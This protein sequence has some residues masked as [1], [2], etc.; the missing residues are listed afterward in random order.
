MAN[1]VSGGV[2]ATYLL[3]SQDL[4]FGQNFGFVYEILIVLSS[5]IMGY[6]VAGLTRQ[7]LVW[8]ASM[9]W[10]SV[11]ATAALFNTFHRNYS[12]PERNHMSMVRFFLLVSIGS[13]V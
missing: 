2:Y 6:S 4:F 3:L 9:I 12:I 10:P 11:L 1:T 13:F 7:F 5:Q 8:P